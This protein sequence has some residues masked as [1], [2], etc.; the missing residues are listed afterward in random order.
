M[1]RFGKIQISAFSKHTLEHVW[2][3]L[4]YIANTLIFILLGT[5]VS[6]KVFREDTTIG[7]EDYLKLLALYV[8]LHLI[9]AINIIGILYPISK[10]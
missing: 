8:L 5:I 3:F 10:L 9:R 6:L 4:A 7:Y 1:S 2:E